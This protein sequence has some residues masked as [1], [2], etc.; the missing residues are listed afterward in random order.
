MAAKRKRVPRRASVACLACPLRDAVVI[1]TGRMKDRSAEEAFELFRQACEDDGMAE[2]DI[3]AMILAV[4]N[5]VIQSVLDEKRAADVPAAE[6]R[7]L[8]DLQISVAECEAT[9]APKN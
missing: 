7:E 8:L 3:R 1:H 4:L 6:L 5:R 2:P 9:D